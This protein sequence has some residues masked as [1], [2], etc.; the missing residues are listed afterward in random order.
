MIKKLFRSQLR[1]NIASSVVTRGVNVIVL[2]VA[3]P[4]YLHYLGYETYGLWLALG[5]VL[6]LAQISN[7]GMAHAVTKLVAEEQGKGNRQAVQQYVTTAISIL[8]VTGGITFAII[9]V[10]KSQIISAF[11]FPGETSRLAAWLLPY[12]GAL[13]IYVLMVQVLTATLAGLGRMD[14]SN[15]IETGGRI[16]LVLTAVPLL[17]SGQGL[18][19]LLFATAFSHFVK[20]LLSL[21]LIRRIVPFR[22]IKLSNIS[23]RCFKKLLHIGMGLFGGSIM[24]MVGIP[25]NKFMLAR[26]VGMNSL[27]VF[28]IAYRGSFQIHGII[29]AAFRA[30]MPEVSRITSEIS[31]AAINRIRALMRR[32]QQLI[33]F[34]GVPLYTVLLFFATPL[35][36]IWL[37]KSFVDTIPLTFRI[38]LVAS[39]INLLLVP[40]YHFL[41][42]IG[43]IKPV[44]M[45]PCIMW[46]SDIV[47]LLI[48]SLCFHK[49]SL[50]VAAGC[51][52]V[53]CTASSSYLIWNYR[54]TMDRYAEATLSIDTL[55]TVKTAVLN[56]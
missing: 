20:H 1:I 11:R 42:G 22:L 37:G 26:Y 33:L 38:I 39:F 13:S 17:Y 7:L 41:I 43:K 12:I 51:L 56:R 21:F 44:F 2:A 50:I 23:K 30:L 53:S 8:C 24:R 54:S 31:T 16:V 27:P 47:L 10:F 6:G 18:K 35:L 49:L 9:L 19:S 34:C 4:I 28:D 46:L 45:F 15:Y 5:A 36:K 29:N 25:F 55:R 3:Y 48:F 52:V 14:L 32:A 40:A